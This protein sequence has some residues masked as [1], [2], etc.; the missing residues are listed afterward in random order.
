VGATVGKGTNYASQEIRKEALLRRHD[1][2]WEESSGQVGR[3]REE[4][5]LKQQYIKTMIK[6]LDQFSFCRGRAGIE[7]KRTRMLT[8]RAGE[9]AERPLD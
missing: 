4:G 2:L 5:I 7:Q 8:P 3:H 1:R 6:T 9:A